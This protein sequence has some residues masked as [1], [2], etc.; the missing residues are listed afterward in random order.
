MWCK[1]QS[2]KARDR[3]VVRLLGQS[4]TLNNSTDFEQMD[5]VPVQCF[6]SVGRKLGFDTY[7]HL[8]TDPAVGIESL[9]KVFYLVNRTFD[10]VSDTKE[11]EIRR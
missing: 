3:Y 11:V 4:L 7:H 6:Q 1:Y 9:V 5:E 2:R 10:I 8:V